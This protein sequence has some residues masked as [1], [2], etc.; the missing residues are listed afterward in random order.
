[1]SATS[2]RA[3]VL[4][5][6]PYGE[7]SQI[8]RLLTERWGVVSVVAR[9]A[10]RTGTR[11]STHLEPFT[12]GEL[13]LHYRDGRELQTLGSF[14]V[15]R[16]RLALAS[17]A[18][19][20]AGASALV[21]LLLRA[22]PEAPQAALLESVEQGLDALESCAPSDVAQQ[23]LTSLWQLVAALGFEPSLDECVRCGEVLVEEEV[24][25]FDFA[26]GGVLCADCGASA[27]GPRVGPGARAEL[28]AFL[29]TVEPGGTDPSHLGAHL[30]LLGDFVTYHVA[31]GRALRSLDLLLG[32]IG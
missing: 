2:T 9:G 25:R 8:A 15:E 20:F 16:A 13:T 24:G 6:T 14:H 10:R 7:T 4:R 29:S 3:V 12:T 22:A 11:S 5:A 30:K 1:M 23:V 27:S 32:L 28:R 26:R 31:E 21:E 19:R 18:T 17:P